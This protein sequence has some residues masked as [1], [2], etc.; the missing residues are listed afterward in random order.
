MISFTLKIVPDTIPASP[1]KSK[2]IFLAIFS[3]PDVP[4]NWSQK[5]IVWTIGGA[6]NAKVDE[7]TAPI[8]LINRSIFGTTAAKPTEIR[9][10]VKFIKALERN[11]L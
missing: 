6:I 1:R 2:N 7:L 11:K 5:I 10:E 9:C 8:R 3:F 4:L